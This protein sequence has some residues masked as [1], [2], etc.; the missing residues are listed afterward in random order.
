MLKILKQEFFFLPI[1]LLLIEVF[2]HF[3]AYAYPDTALFDRGSLFD[4]FIVSVWQITWISAATLLLL[5]IVFPEA[6][7]SIRRFHEHFTR[8][9]PEEQDKIS[10]RLWL[11]IFLSLVFLVGMRGQNK[12]Q[13]LRHQLIDTLHSQLNVREATGHNDGVD[14]ERYLH[15][16]GQSSGAS[17]CAAFTSYNYN[18]IG[19]GKPINPVSAWAPAFNNNKYI[20]WSQKLAKAHKASNPKPG[21]CFTLYYDALKR[22]GHVGFIVAEAGNYFITIEGNTGVYGSREGSGVHKLKRSKQ[23]IYSAS[24]YITI[25][26]KQNEKTGI[27][28]LRG[29]LD[30]MYAKDHKIIG[31][32]RNP[33]QGQYDSK[34]GQ[35]LVSGFNFDCERQYDYLG[36][37]GDRGFNWRSEY[38]GNCYRDPYEQVHYIYQKWSFKDRMY[39][40]GTGTKGTATKSANSRLTCQVGPKAERS[41]NYSDQGGPVYTER[42]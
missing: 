7:T 4:S 8:F 36:S 23:K 31:E 26:I 14:V 39:M 38:A 34:E 13:Y 35:Y 33:G 32:Y 1:M 24:N 9:R 20:I 40:Q 5:R 6:Y 19:I 37:T 17:W 15:F 30:P 18:A 22:V 28:Y 27:N 21:D 2:R 41:K 11:T 29:D 25:Y 42:C 16:V 10:H 12:E 3:I